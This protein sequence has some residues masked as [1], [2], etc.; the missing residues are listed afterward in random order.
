MNRR[1]IFAVLLTACVAVPV[2][3]LGR[4][5]LADR[6]GT[7]E[8]AGRR[9]SHDDGPSIEPAP[10]TPEPKRPPPSARSKSSSRCTKRW[11]TRSIRSIATTSRKS[12][13]AN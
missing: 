9:P 13:A 3:L 1:L 4:A 6:S 7:G 11:P 5:V 10:K 2:G 8:N 12:T